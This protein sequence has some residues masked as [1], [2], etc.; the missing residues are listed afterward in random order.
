MA[1]I[2]ISESKRARVAYSFDDVSIVPSRRTREP[3]DVSLNW[4][5]DAYR[6]DLPL[7]ADFINTN[8]AGNR[9]DARTI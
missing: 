5:I 8:R 2:E 9:K 4:Q 3:G 7:L 1:D 6:F